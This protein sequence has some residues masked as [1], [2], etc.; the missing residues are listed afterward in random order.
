M[1]DPM[2]DFIYK[3][4]EVPRE[5]TDKIGKSIDKDL[6]KMHYEQIKQERLAY[7]EAS[8]IIINS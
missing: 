4:H 5:I 1:L 7:K 6:E 2:Y 8:N 3:L